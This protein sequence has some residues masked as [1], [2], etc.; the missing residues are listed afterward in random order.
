VLYSLVSIVRDRNNNQAKEVKEYFHSTSIKPY[1][2][3]WSA[4][5]LGAVMLA[6][7]YFALVWPE[8]MHQLE[9][10]LM[11]IAVMALVSLMH[12]H[13]VGKQETAIATTQG[14]GY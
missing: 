10:G 14:E 7:G 13:G 2:V 6:C 3:P 8:V 4:A 9:G 1:R 5:P 12:R 11:K